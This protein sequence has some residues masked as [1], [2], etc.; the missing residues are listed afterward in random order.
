MIDFGKCFTFAIDRFK[1]NPAFYIVTGLFTLLIPCIISFGINFVVGFMLAGISRALNMNLIIANIL[2]QAVGVIIGIFVSSLIVAPVL[3]AFFRD[4]ESEN[5]GENVQPASLI[6]CFG[7]FSQTALAYFISSII[8]SIGTLFCVIPGILLSPIVPMSI[9]F[10][11]R[12]DNSRDAIK[13]SFD[14]LMSNPM[15]ILYTILF[16][17]IASVGLLACCIGVIVTMPIAYAAF[18]KMMKQVLGEDGSPASPE[19]PAQIKAAI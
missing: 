15:T 9:F 4:M 10:V 5:K 6:N 12:G 14:I 13:K 2:V 18:Y 11:S 19:T 3:A 1:A 8:V 17:L 7:S 16:F